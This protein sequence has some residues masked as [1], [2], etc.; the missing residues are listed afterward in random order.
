MPNYYILKD[1]RHLIPKQDRKRK[2]KILIEMRRLV[3]SGSFSLLSSNIETYQSSLKGV[4]ARRYDDELSEISYLF[5]VALLKTGHKNEEVSSHFKDAIQLN[6]RN[7][8]A[9]QALREL[10]AKFSEHSLLYRVEVEGRTDT[11]ANPRTPEVLPFLS[12]YEVI[13]DTLEE[14]KSMILQ[15]DGWRIGNTVE[16]TKYSILREAPR[17]LKGVCFLPGFIF[18]SDEEIKNEDA[19]DRIS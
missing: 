6:R 8:Q 11:L 5:G 17:E 14:V 12:T 1:D 7:T 2:K 16:I 19:Q 13:A 4:V 3:S 15:Y 10:D 18:Y 9:L